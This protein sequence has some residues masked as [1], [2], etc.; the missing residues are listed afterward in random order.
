[1]AVPVP[2]NIQ[3]LFDVGS[4]S[5]S[6]QWLKILVMTSSIRYFAAAKSKMMSNLPISSVV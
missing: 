5:A 4:K 6:T 2:M 3:D 1:M